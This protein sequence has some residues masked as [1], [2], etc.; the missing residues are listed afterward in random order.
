VFGSTYNWLLFLQSTSSFDT[1]HALVQRFFS[2]LLSLFDLNS[3]FQVV[4]IIS[5]SQGYITVLS[6]SSVLYMLSSHK[7][8]VTTIKIFNVYF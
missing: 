2:F 1:V 3:E 7:P 5:V 6:I 4:N 8:D